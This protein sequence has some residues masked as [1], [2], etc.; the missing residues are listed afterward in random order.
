M[1]EVLLLILIFS[2]SHTAEKVLIE[3]RR[4]RKILEY[5]VTIREDDKTEFDVVIDNMGPTVRA[6]LKRMKSINSPGKSLC[7]SSIPTFLLKRL[8]FIFIVQRLF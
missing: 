4:I 8:N 3:L 1:L 6:S 5:Q 7:I 2:L